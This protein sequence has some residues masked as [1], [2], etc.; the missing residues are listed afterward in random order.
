MSFCF[1]NLRL[2]CL[3]FYYNMWKFSV[4]EK[5]SFCLSLR[6][7]LQS[8]SKIKLGHQMLEKGQKGRGSL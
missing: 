1:E 6:F 5:V 3:F 8:K 2:A 7:T 4:Y